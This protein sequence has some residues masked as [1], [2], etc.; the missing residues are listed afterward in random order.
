MGGT[1]GVSGCGTPAAMSYFV[2]APTPFNIDV[3]EV[4]RCQYEAWLATNPSTDGQDP[5]CFGNLTFHP[6]PGCMLNACKGANCSSRPQVCIDWCDAY[7]YCKA[8]GKRL[9][10]KM[11]GGP[12]PFATAHTNPGVSQ[13]GYACTSGGADDYPYGDAYTPQA[14]NGL[15]MGIGYPVDVGSLPDC[16][17]FEDQPYFQAVKDMSGNVEEWEN[18]CDGT[19]DMMDYCRLRGGSF[20]DDAPKLRCASDHSLYRSSRLPYIGFRCCAD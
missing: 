3:T 17:S 11:G 4:S 8:I 7:V 9:C 15:D 18:S 14:C 16:R 12:T 1:A 2:S 19:N 20:Q 10:G 6:L 13:F 5:W